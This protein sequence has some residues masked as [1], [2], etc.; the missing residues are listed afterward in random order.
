L[1]LYVVSFDGKKYLLY[2]REKRFDIGNKEDF[3]GI[4]FGPLIDY[5]IS[6]GLIE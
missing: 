6:R 1:G 4:G 5:A 3:L 2:N